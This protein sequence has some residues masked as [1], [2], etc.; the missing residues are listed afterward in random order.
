MEGLSQY[1]LTKVENFGEENLG[2]IK[3]N[4]LVETIPTVLLI[5]FLLI[6]QNLWV[7]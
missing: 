4:Q 2:E 7:K 6:W 1:C 5:H 3:E